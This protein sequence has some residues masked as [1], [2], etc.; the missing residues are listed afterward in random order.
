[1]S[2]SHDD[3]KR[4]LERKALRDVRGLVDDIETRDREEPREA[5]KLAVWVMAA[6][7]LVVVLAF[8]AWKVRPSWFSPAPAKPTADMT[9]AQYVQQ[10]MEK[11]ERASRVA[12]V[13][14]EMA[15]LDGG[16]EVVLAIGPNGYIKTLDVTK[17]SFNPAVD[18][19]G[20]RIVK[21]AE[22][23]GPLPR[24]VLAKSADLRFTGT[25]R[26]T[27]SGRAE[28]SLTLEGKWSPAP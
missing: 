14:T 17:S 1:M 18:V 7:A 25:V 8:S 3:A 22:P 11:I 2:D 15:G 10:S 12:R 9:T 16:V 13:R 6:G 20:A 4:D 26:I 19:T 23:F 5:A 24:E 21:F 28:P 27:S